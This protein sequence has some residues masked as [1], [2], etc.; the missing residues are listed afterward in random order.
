MRK[1]IAVLALSTAA[2]AATSIYLWSELREARNQVELLSRESS[3]PPM[4]LSS[5][6]PAQHGADPNAKPPAAARASTTPSPDEIAKARQVVHEEEF[7]DASRRRL[8]QLSDPAMRAQ[9]LEEW[10]EA[11]LPNKANYVR[12][13]GISDVDAERLLDVLA[14]QN[15]VQAEAY[16]R[17]AL[18][19]RC[20]NQALS[21]ETGAARQQALTDLLGTEKLQRFEQ[22]TYTGVERHMVSQFL[23]EKIPAGSQ[24]S[25]DQAEQLIDVL[26]QERRLV[27]AAIRQRGL[28]PFVYPMEGVVFAF[29]NSVFE[30]GDSSER[31]KEA[32]D[33]NRR[34][35]A[36][37]KSILTPQQLAAF[38]QM[39]EAA[40]VG[41]KFWMRQ[42]ERDL[43]TRAASGDGR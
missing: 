27:E 28:E 31:L 36:R 5:S 12:Y 11:N 7:R 21:R 40:I 9:M 20:D 3:E 24:L 34:I 22:Y 2:L 23:R 29:Q 26:A 25:E 35:H 10:K 19:P 42:Q 15:F 17:C 4:P 32:A 33:Y 41:V 38:E 37:A 43:A 8:A 18:Q 30:P 6:T 1:P 16:A 14:E 13:L 39:Q